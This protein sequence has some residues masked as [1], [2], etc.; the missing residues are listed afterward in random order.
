MALQRM[1]PELASAG[2]HLLD[3]ALLDRRSSAWR[4]TG[5]SRAHLPGPH[6][7]GLRPGTPVPPHLEHEPEP[8][9]PARG[10]DRREEHFARIKVPGTIP[11]LVAVVPP[12]G[13]ERG[14]PESASSGWSSSS[15]PISTIS[16]RACGA[17]R[18][19]R[20]GSCGTRRW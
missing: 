11:R 14:P 15:R 13:E 17:A 9:H 18:P 2:I 20:S 7:A 4:P 16:S 12:A 10:R 3:Y 8:G 5:T 19:I 1:L 6:P